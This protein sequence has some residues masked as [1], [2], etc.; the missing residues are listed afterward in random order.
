MWCR[1]LGGNAARLM[2]QP[3]TCR[4]RHATSWI[5]GEAAASLTEYLLRW[6]KD[7]DLGCRFLNHTFSP[8]LDS[9]GADLP[10]LF[11]LTDTFFWLRT[12]PS[13]IPA[14]ASSTP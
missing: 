2:Q 1:V 14:D 10:S 3:V 11:T 5:C 8:C 6:A 9:E 4:G 13:V 12:T 7:F